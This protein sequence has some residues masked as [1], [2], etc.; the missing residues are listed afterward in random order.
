MLKYGYLMYITYVLIDCENVQP[1]GLAL[2]NSQSSFHVRVFVGATQTKISVDK[3][4]LPLQDCKRLNFDSL[5][6]F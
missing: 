2:L 1:E 4:V 3:L 6:V 5:A